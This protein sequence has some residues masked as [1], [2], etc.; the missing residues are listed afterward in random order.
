MEDK[1]V[2][3][4]TRGIEK[5]MH[6]EIDVLV[7]KAYEEGYK[8]GYSEGRDKH[9]EAEIEAW[10]KGVTDAFEYLEMLAS[11]LVDLAVDPKAA[12]I[13]SF[14]RNTLQSK[15][16]TAVNEVQEHVKRN[17]PYEPKKGDVVYD[18]SGNLCCATN[19]D[20]HIHVVYENG[21]THKW[22]KTD[23]FTKASESASLFV[24]SPDPNCK[25][26]ILKKEPSNDQS[27]M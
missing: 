1:H 8:I 24:V 14:I 19:T 16:V 15:M 21:K 3:M 9:G 17:K 7:R 18:K 22:D 2:V 23:K 6:A 25:G 26:V 13:Y 27:S 10:G 12:N 20:T 4:S 5:N 11:D